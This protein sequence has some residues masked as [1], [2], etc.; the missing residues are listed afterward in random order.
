MLNY[1]TSLT[2][3]MFVMC[4]LICLEVLLS[5]FTPLRYLKVNT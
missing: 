3:I 4:R 1:K 5:A 2:Y